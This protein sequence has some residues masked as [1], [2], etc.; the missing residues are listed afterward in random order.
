MKIL[1][2]ILYTAFALLICTEIIYAQDFKIAPNTTLPEGSNF[3]N[4]STASDPNN[5]FL[6][7]WIN[8][9]H[10]G[11]SFLLRNYACRISKTG[12]MLD[13]TAIFLCKGNWPY[14]C[15]SV[16]F[17]GG[18]WIIAGSQGSLYEYVGAI[19]LS[20]SGTVLDSLPV[21]ICWSIGMATIKYPTIAT[22]GQEI[23]CV[24]GIAGEGIYG[25]IFDSDLNTVV[26][27]FLILS[28]GLVYSMPTVCTN[29]NN[30]FITF[31]N[32]DDN[33]VKLVI[34]NPEGQI[35][36]TQ[37]V[38]EKVNVLSYFG[39][40]T[41]TTLN[42][43]TYITYLD[44][45][46]LWI[47]R[48]SSDGN[49]IDSSPVKIVESPDF[50]LL[51]QELDIGRRAP[52]YTDLVWANECFCFFW[53]RMSD[54]G[55]SMMSFKP[56]LSTGNYQ[57]VLLNSQCRICFELHWDDW[58]GRDSYSLIRASSLGDKVLT[59]WIDEREG[60]TRVYGNFFDVNE[61]TGIEQEENQIMIPEDFS[62][63]QNYPN[64]FNPSTTIEFSISHSSEVSLTV[65]NCLGQNVATLVSEKL[66]AGRYKTQWT[67]GNVASGVY[68]C[69]L[70]AGA[71]TETKK[72]VVLK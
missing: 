59:A 5:G 56:D 55:I 39:F 13:S 30:F 2:S 72:L 36:S 15:P 33:K 68:F 63:S 6:V 23:L 42:D 54:P 8:E 41:I 50:D 10:S 7:T 11:A 53:P 12:E 48:Y 66:P 20:P 9:Y 64:P 17:A 38:Y 71:F 61:Y 31:L 58:P 69:R 24:T 67:A 60:N 51:V 25:S 32:W 27:R 4:V 47:K 70:Q 16:V 44:A 28:Q 1:K 29:G 57:P 43:T 62:I 21:N 52:G 19:R 49:P 26:D 46:A 65:Y 3:F 45:S 40:P 34:V 14:T 37:D 35:L 22:N 18:N